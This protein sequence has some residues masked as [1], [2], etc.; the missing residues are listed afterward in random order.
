MVMAAVTI[1]AGAT[2][3]DYSTVTG[4]FLQDE[5]STDPSTFDY[6]RV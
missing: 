4:Y 5:N 2:S 3:I 6:V 1:S